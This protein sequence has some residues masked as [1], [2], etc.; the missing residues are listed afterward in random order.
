MNN[1]GNP[2]ADAPTPSKGIEHIDQSINSLMDAVTLVQSIADKIAGALPEENTGGTSKLASVPSSA[3]A[4]LHDHAER[5][6]MAANRIRSAI[7]RI[8]DAI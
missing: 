6:Q 5:I 8:D 4:V 7:V 1:Y 3:R 2:T